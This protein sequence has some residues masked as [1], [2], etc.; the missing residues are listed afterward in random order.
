MSIRNLDKLFKPASVALIGASSRER[1]LGAIALDNLIRGG[2]Q[3]AIYPVN[4]KYE[5]LRALRCYHKLS[6]LPKAP[7]LAVICT[8]PATLPGLI[9]DLGAMGTRAASVMTA[10]LARAIVI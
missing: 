2:Y 7:D 6:Q 10:G 4:P 1:S 5:E 8:P 3:G 9:R